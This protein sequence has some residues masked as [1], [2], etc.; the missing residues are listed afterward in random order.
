Q[1]LRNVVAAVA[2]A[3]DDRA[4]PFPVFAVG[5]LARV[6]P[7]AAELRERRNVREMGNSADAGREHDVPRP[8][9]ALRTVGALE[10]HR[11]ARFAFVVRC[12]TKLGW[13]PEVELHRL[14]VP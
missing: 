3:D 13:G 8:E 4:D 7:L 6:E 11:P 2:C 1:V 14:A 12:A 9:R 10:G 5:V